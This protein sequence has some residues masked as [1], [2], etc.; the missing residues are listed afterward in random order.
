M[1]H[2]L[3]LLTVTAVATFVYT[4]CG[5][6][7]DSGGTPTTS[8]TLTAEN[9]DA[10]LERVSSTIPGCT[11]S[12]TAMASAQY[13]V[14]VP[15]VITNVT[16]SSA[17]KA[18][19]NADPATQTI[20]C[21]NLDSIAE[22]NITLTSNVDQT[23]IS[24]TFNQCNIG[25][26]TQQ[27]TT[28]DGLVNLGLSKDANGTLT[29]IT[30]STGSSGITV[31]DTNVSQNINLVLSG[32]KVEVGDGTSTNPLAVTL[33][34]LKFTDKIVAAQSFTVSN[35]Y[36]TEYA[37]MTG[38]IYLDLDRCSYTDVNGTFAFASEGPIVASTDGTL[39]GSVKVTATDDSNMVFTFTNSTGIVDVTLNGS[40][41]GTMD[42]T[43]AATDLTDT[44]LSGITL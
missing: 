20:E 16:S 44:N 40:A 43:E 32:F 4:G 29:S 38:D 23:A 24:A 12:G 42:C 36:A 27:N 15:T 33:G 21:L 35:C 3:N 8:S 39:N 19:Q 11:Y 6:G 18:A 28:I 1:K 22:G 34:T 17:F 30:A 26:L 41:F 9:A 37:D 13:S 7:G 2:W 14:I 31:V 5:G 25:S 10:F